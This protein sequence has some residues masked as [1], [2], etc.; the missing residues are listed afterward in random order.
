MC[1]IVGILQLDNKTV[2]E[3]RLKRMNRTMTHRGPDAEGYYFDGALGFGQR[4]LSIIDLSGGKQP[5]A[6]ED[7]T[8]WVTFNGEIYNFLDLK[9]DLE[10]KGHTF[11]THSDTE[12]LVHLYEEYGE[13]SVSLLQGMYA[14]AIWDSNK[15][16]LFIA[17]DRIGIK[18][19][20]Y[21]F[22]GNKFIFASE[23]KA[24]LAY[25]SICHEL[26]MTAVL[27][28]LTFS[29]I[30]SPKSIFKHIKKLDAAHWMKISLQK[31]SL[32]IQEY[33]DISFAE[34]FSASQEEIEAMIR[35]ELAASV[36]SH[37]I[38]DVPLGAFLSGGIDSSAVVASMAQIISDP[39][40]TCSIGLGD[41]TFTEL[42]YAQEVAE[43]YKTDHHALVVE[44]EAMD[45]FDT[46]LYH[47]DEPFA[48]TSA[49]PSKKKKKIARQKVTV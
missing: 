4:R 9:K 12:V 19:V 14:Y 46:L 41:H 8:V 21:Y 42:P 18:P 17:R 1:G 48:D 23:I 32:E 31:P 27:D 40:K 28:Y 3:D 13:K 33:W 35:H 15:K 5:L 2:Q 20:Y 36:K 47:Y 34:K 44:P 16:E 7:R 43:Q 26:D 30:P 24:I 29:F 22:D 25:G 45:I 38:S 10:S 39:V 37:L 11:A 49:L 6:N